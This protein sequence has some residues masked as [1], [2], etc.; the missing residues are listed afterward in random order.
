MQKQLADFPML[1]ANIYLKDSDGNVTDERL[2]DPYK[3]F[4][5]NGLKVAV[6]GLTTKDTEKL[7]KPY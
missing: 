6:I 5:I 2:F 7:V 3:V 1:A 4:T